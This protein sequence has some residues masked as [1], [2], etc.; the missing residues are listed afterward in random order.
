M[1]YD[2]LTYWTVS[3]DGLGGFE[4][5]S[6]TIIKGRWE[7]KVERVT[8][9]TGEEFISRAVAYVD[10]DISTD[11]FLCKGIADNVDPS[12]INAYRIRRI[13]VSTDLRRVTKIRKVYM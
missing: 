13:D 4:Y 8:T 5:G 11:G 1:Y 3:N 2:T 9:Q 7:D 10:R 12:E 6:P